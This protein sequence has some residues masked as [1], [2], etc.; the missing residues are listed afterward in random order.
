M[1]FKR[2][3]AV[4]GV[5][6]LA[7]AGWGVLSATVF[8]RTYDSGGRLEGKIQRNW[9]GPISQAVPSFH[10]QRPAAPSPL[11]QPDS[12]AV[13]VD[14]KLEQR[15][16]GLLWYPLFNCDFKAT[17]AFANPT[18]DSRRVEASLPF[19]EADAT[20]DNVNIAVDSAPFDGVV[21]PRQGVKLSFDIPPGAQRH[22]TFAYRVRGLGNWRYL[23]NSS[24]GQLKN[25]D[26]VVTTNFKAVNFPEDTLS[27]SSSEPCGDGLRL[28]WRANGL[29]SNQDIGVEM[30]VKLNPGPLAGRM[31]MFAPFSLLFFFVLL[32]AV[33]VIHKVPIH[34]M[35][36]FFVAAGFFAFHLLFAYLVDLVDVNLAFALAAATSILLVVCYLR[37]ALGPAFPWKLA[38]AGQLY[39]L[40]LFSYSFFLQG[41][42]GMTVTLGA[43]IT[44]AAL[45]KA[46]AKTDWS[47]VFAP[48]P[49]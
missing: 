48:N 27:P 26:V 13:E 34:P 10:E 7:C 49:R 29:I 42:T 15:R 4:A 16:K 20:Y 37:A 11:V 46:T 17:Y 40:L 18:P 31:T 14:L 25:L 1:S 33:S 9:G 36:Y 44:L 35:H 47:A 3:M 22:L 21:D 41:M 43:I 32:L 24:A 23:L 39:Y 28:A 2:I 38:C 30:P 19:P 6:L 12:C 8:Y 5:F 45:M